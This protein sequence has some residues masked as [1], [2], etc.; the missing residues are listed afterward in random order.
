MTSTAREHWLV[1][2]LGVTGEA[3]V[4]HALASGRDVSVIEDHPE[5][6]NFERHLDTLGE[7]GV[8]VTTTPS[9]AA[10]AEVCLSSVDL[11][12][13][14]P[15]VRP[16]HLVL[17]EAQ[18]LGIPVRSEID[19]AGE[20][21]AAQ[22]GPQ[23]AA[24]TGTNGKT[25]VTRLVTAMLVESGFIAKPGGNI[26][27]PLI[28]LVAELI[29]NR[30]GGSGIAVAEV[31]S[32]QLHYSTT[33]KPSVAAI[34]N[35]GD[36]H[37]DWHGSFGA[38]TSDKARIFACQD[39]QDVLIY[40]ADD[41]IVAEL[42]LG[43]LAL[44]D[45]PRLVPFSL[46]P[47][48]SVGFRIDAG[49]IRAADDSAIIEV[50][51]LDRHA[52]HDLANALA[53]CAM[54]FELGASSHACSKILRKFPGLPHRL[55]LVGE[56]SGVKFYDDSKATNPHATVQAVQAFQKCVLIAGGRNK[57]LDLGSLRST[58]EHL[59]GVVAIGEAA[60]EVANVF[61]SV[62]PVRYAKSM[63]EV[64]DLAIEMA[65]AGDVVLL[66]PACASFDW[67]QNYSERG[68]DFAAE[69]WRATDGFAAAPG[70]DVLA[71]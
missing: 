36:D 11:V 66:S 30:T 4:A 54:A 71:N 39:A 58:A 26:G 27:K 44:T 49:L 42:A 9:D 17:Q 8:I 69:V 28:S 60:D 41:P 18:R 40:N 32:F 53:A 67:Y 50:T 5:G 2:G 12:I 35:L 65:R 52:P 37:L 34:L 62:V 68:D 10:G 56:A 19:L 20:L 16:D 23:I 63:R 1:L 31:S 45:G 33:F 64:V 25:T 48:A 55:S 61:R 14:S 47:H 3:V 29:P 15:G 46:D 24:I 57:G 21:A 59:R 43:T 6:L 13:T 70:G 51:S 38:Y 7:A 22:E